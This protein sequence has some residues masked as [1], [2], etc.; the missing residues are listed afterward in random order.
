MF[1]RAGIVRDLVRDLVRDHVRAANIRGILVRDNAL[2]NIKYS[3]I[4]KMKYTFDLRFNPG[5][6]E[7]EVGSRK[8]P[9]K[10]QRA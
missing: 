6:S 2:H 3:S 7:G 10:P 5:G 9:S 8:S 4:H 1:I